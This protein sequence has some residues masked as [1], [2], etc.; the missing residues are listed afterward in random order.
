MPVLDPACEETPTLDELLAAR[1]VLD[2]EQPEK[3][4]TVSGVSWERYLAVDAELGHDCSGPRLFYLDQ[5]LEIVTTSNKHEIV[6]KWLAGF[7][8]DYFLQARLKVAPRGEATIRLLAEAGAEPDESWCVG[9]E[10]EWPDIVL[11]IALS[12]GGLSKLKVYQRFG[13]PEVWIW[14][15]GRLEFHALRPDGSGYD[16]QP[17]SAFTPDLDLP[18][19]Y[20][21]LEIPDWSE[22]RLAFRDGLEGRQ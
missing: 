3:R 21:C 10:K 19:V 8:E 4:L 20:H 5:V 17:Q 2:R 18:L 6:K 11:E 1:P 14:R 13:I 22:A 9:T 7:L 15:R 12:S 16:V